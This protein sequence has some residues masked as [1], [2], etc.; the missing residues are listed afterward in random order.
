MSKPWAQ[1]E[2]YEQ[3]NRSQKSRDTTAVFRIRIQV[4]KTDYYGYDNYDYDDYDYDDYDYD[5]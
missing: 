2:S 3:K 1:V 5:D 4:L